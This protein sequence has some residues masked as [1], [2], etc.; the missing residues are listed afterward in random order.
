MELTARTKPGSL[1]VQLA[2]EL[3]ESFADNGR[4]ARSQRHVHPRRT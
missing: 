3:A 1:L 2:E 4:R